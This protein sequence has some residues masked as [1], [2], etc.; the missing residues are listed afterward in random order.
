MIY[1]PLPTGK[2]MHELRCMV[3]QHFITLA[4]MRAYMGLED[5]AEDLLALAVKNATKVGPE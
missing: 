3:K 5:N 1:K 2:Q 4:E